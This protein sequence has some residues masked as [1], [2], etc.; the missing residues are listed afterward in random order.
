MTNGSTNE[1]GRVIGRRGGVGA[2]GDPVG[3]AGAL[4]DELRQRITA[5]LAPVGDA[6][7]E[8]YVGW[9]AALDARACPARFRAGGEEGWGFPGWSAASAGP[10]IARAALHAY[11]DRDRPPGRP[12]A[13]PEPLTLVREW[14]KGTRP[15]PDS[16]VAGWVAERLDAGDGPALAAAAAGATRWMAGFV[17]ALGWPLPDRLRLAGGGRDSAPPPRWRPEK[18]ST[19][20]VAPGADARLGR[21]TGS[22]DF[23]VVVHR[24]VVAGDDR[25]GERAAFEATAA[26]LVIGVVPASVLVTAGD[27]GERLRVTVDE[28]L[29]GLGAGLV[30]GVVEQRVIA[31]EQGW[32]AADTVP[33]PACR[34]CPLAGTCPPGDA[35]LA[36][37]GR[38]RGGL[39]SILP[40]PP[41]QPGQPARPG[42]TDGAVVGQPPVGAA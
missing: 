38:W 5:R 10:S 41:D 40:T 13:R 39:P 8:V 34:H 26:G 25:L 2:I 4:R 15:A 16:S 18:G 31:T 3:R 6:A 12:P 20:T 27:T 11:L 1:P 29:L 28:G 14:M 35:W 42:H 7:G 36:G 32:A 17:R 22:G 30:A 24:P 33:S 9:F 23:A 19:V 37:P 21:V